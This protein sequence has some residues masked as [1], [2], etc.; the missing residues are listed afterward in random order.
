MKRKTGSYAFLIASIALF[1]IAAF[2]A[3]IDAE[4]IYFGYKSHYE[5]GHVLSAG[6]FFVSS[7]LAN[8]FIGYE[9]RK[10]TGYFM[11][12]SALTGVPFAFTQSPLMEH[13][14]ILFT[15]AAT[16]VLAVHFRNKT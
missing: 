16:F 5:F 4:Q 15:S 2:A 14:Y 7:A 6:I 9:L 10:T 11:I 1:G 3:R 12:F 13:I 8:I